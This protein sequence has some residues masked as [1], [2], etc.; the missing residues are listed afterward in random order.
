MDYNPQIQ[1]ILQLIYLKTIFTSDSI[2]ADGNIEGIKKINVLNWLSGI[3]Y[4]K[5]IICRF[6]NEVHEL[7]QEICR[8]PGIEI[9]QFKTNGRRLKALC[10]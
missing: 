1:S 9:V 4:R 5:H 7:A 2:F 3:R 8:F 10:G 6:F